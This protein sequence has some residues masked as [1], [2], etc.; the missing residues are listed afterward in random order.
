MKKI[1]ISLFLLILSIL[2][3]ISYYLEKDFN[4]TNTIIFFLMYN[5]LPLAF[6]INLIININKYNKKK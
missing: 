4:Q 5:C 2:L 6:L 3:S 1:V